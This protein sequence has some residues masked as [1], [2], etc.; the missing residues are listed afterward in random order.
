LL[1]QLHVSQNL[2]L[3][4]TACQVFK[5]ELDF[6]TRSDRPPPPQPLDSASVVADP[7]TIPRINFGK[8]M[9]FSLI[10]LTAVDGN[11]SVC[12]MGAERADTKHTDHGK[13]WTLAVGYYVVIPQEYLSQ[14]TDPKHKVK[15]VIV[16]LPFDKTADPE[17]LELHVRPLKATK[18]HLKQVEYDPPAPSEIVLFSD[19]IYW[20][21]KLVLLLALV[22]KPS[23]N[24]FF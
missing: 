15:L 14:L 20:F 22:F 24:D 5:N 3:F 17:S 1:Y 11:V 16:V 21:D 13:T 10:C 19:V 9:T 7:F 2:G 23:S 12:L 6:R 4:L 18:D 8:S